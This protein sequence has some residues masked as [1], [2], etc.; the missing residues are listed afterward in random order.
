[1]VIQHLALKLCVCASLCVYVWVGEWM[2]SRL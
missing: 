2:V 1:M